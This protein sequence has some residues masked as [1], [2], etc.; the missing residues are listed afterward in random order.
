MYGLRYT[1]LD[2][3]PYT[4]GTLD[5]LLSV[6]RSAVSTDE[7]RARI[8]DRIRAH[9]ERRGLALSRLADEAG[10]GRATLWAIIAGR[11]AVTCDTL[12]KLA[13]A[14]GVDPAELVRAPRQPKAAGPKR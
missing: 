11:S 3:R 10:I 5:S 7:L 1:R 9:A 13:A 6:P 4:H 2:G 12:A 14:L 8:A